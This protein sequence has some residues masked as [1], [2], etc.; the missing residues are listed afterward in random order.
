MAYDEA[1][2][3]RVRELLAPLDG[4]DE[5]KMF[6]GISFM[7]GG[8]Y[9]CGVLND[10]LVVRVSP[11]LHDEVL[12]EPNAREMDFTGRPMRGWVYVAPD[13]TTADGSLAT[14]VDRGVAHARSLP[15]K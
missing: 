8:N 6:G 15:P 2:A 12:G 5:R 3:E 9:C 7:L 4:L 13:G 10:D 14:W 11:E 1:L